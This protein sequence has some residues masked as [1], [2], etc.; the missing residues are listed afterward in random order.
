MEKK[1]KDYP[2]IIFRAK[3]N[4]DRYYAV[5]AVLE[6]IDKIYFM[7]IL[8]INESYTFVTGLKVLEGG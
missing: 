5:V 4:V 7:C 6:D 1:T 3:H 8:L 2:K